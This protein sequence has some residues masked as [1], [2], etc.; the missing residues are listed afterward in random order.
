MGDDINMAAR[1]MSTAD[2]QEILVSKRTKD[3]VAALVDVKDRGE[4]K[5]KGKEILIPTF[6]VLGRSSA[7]MGGQRAGGGAEIFIGRND[8]LEL[9]QGRIQSLLDGSGQ[10]VCVI[11]EGGLGKSRLGRE[12][13]S[14]LSQQSGGDNVSIL[15]AQAL[16]FSEQVSHW[17]AAQILRA[18]LKLKADATEDDV[19]FALWELGEDLLGKENAREAIPFLAHLLNLELE[20][21]WASWVSE[22]DPKVRRKQTFWAAREFFAA[23]AKRQPTLIVIED[24]HFADEGSLALIEELLQTTVQAPLMLLLLFRPQR[25]KGCWRLREHIANA[26]PHRYTEISLTNLDE[27]EGRKLLDALLPGAVFPEATYEEVFGKTAGNPFYLEE[28]V[29]SLIESNAVFPDEENEGQWLVSAGI[30]AIS[31]P[32]S[33]QGAIVARIDR[34]TEEARLALQ[35]ASV[36]GRRFQ[37]DVLKNMTEADSELGMLL[38]QLERGDMVKPEAISGDPSYFFP[39]AL[40]QEVAYDNLLRRRRQ[41]LHRRVG[42]TLENLLE[43]T[44][45][46]ESECELLAYHFHLSDD[47]EKAA[48]YLEM[49]G[50]K[51]RG[52]YALGT[53]LAHYQKLLALRKHQKDLPG[54][55][56]VLYTLGS[57]AYEMGS[58]IQGES[59]LDE[60]VTLLRELNDPQN[61]A[62]SVMYLGM[63]ALKQGD[64]PTSRAHHTHALKLAR[65]REDEFQEGIHITNLA[66]VSL[67]LGQ[68]AEALEQFSR[69]LEM[70]IR[71]NDAKGQGFSRFFIGLTNLNL[72]D[73]QAAQEAIDQALAL[74][75]GADDKRGIAYSYYGLGLHALATGDNEAACTQLEQ[76]LGMFT[77]LDLSAE[78]IETLSN[79]ALAQLAVG[80]PDAA[81]GTS[82]RAMTLLLEQKDVEEVQQI[83]LNHYLV[84]SAAGEPAAGE[85]LDKAFA[86]MT[87]QAGRIED[88]AERK[89][90]LCEVPVNRKISELQQAAPKSTRK[91]AKLKA[92]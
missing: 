38:A 80:S 74:W 39:D 89:V 76:A 67:R 63:I 20:G 30:E 54:Q 65:E 25:D 11:G 81:R 90:F 55:A 14:W 73:T 47:E 79:L 75:Q 41:E 91:K 26:L 10:I 18:S 71:A 51:A 92:V 2:W 87:E 59:W 23:L 48:Q 33:L 40:V 29:R 61:E 49:A 3:R 62:W 68:Y 22:L 88:E 5:V 66:R 84:L 37:T 82:D 64:Y 27:D 31:V 52:E 85:V 44:G 28:V 60:S 45:Q 32:D 58:Y 13:F 57:M 56:S 16:S 35:M 53:A 8:E 7:A 19:L 70:K 34:L 21:E 6:E 17:L 42:E 69:S 72:G 1:L 9:L 86:A 36:I 46:I 4:L 83:Y 43:G 77:E 50:K 12:A 15:R 24:M 78:I